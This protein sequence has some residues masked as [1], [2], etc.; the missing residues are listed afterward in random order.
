MAHLLRP[1]PRA[2][3]LSSAFVL[4]ISCWWPPSAE[5]AIACEDPET[6]VFSG[7]ID[8]NFAGGQE[9]A[10]AGARLTTYLQSVGAP[11][12]NFDSGLTNRWIAHTFTGL[13]T[14]IVGATLRFRVCGIAGDQGNDSLL[15]ESH[16]GGNFAW[17]QFLG[18]LA[19]GTPNSWAAGQCLVR[20]LDLAALP[21]GL[22]LSG[23]NVLASL[24]DG[25]LDF[26]VQDD[27]RVDFAELTVQHCPPADCA[28]PPR[29]LKAW[30]PFDEAAGNVTNELVQNA[31][32]AWSGNL[33]ATPGKVA[34]ALA[35]GGSSA[36]VT[37]P[38]GPAVDVGT[39]DFSIDFW[40]RSNQT[41]GI[42]ALLEKRSLNPAKGWTVFLSSGRLAFQMA[43]GGSSFCD[44]S[45]A[46]GCTN[47]DS[48]VPVADGT[49]KFIGITVDRDQP[50]GLRFYVGN[51]LVSTQNPTL[52]QGSLSNAAP[53]YFGRHAD[54]SAGSSYTGD[55]DEVELFDRVLQ[56]L[57]LL[58]ILDAGGK[59][60][61]RV[62][63]EAALSLCPNR[64]VLRSKPRICN[65]SSED[66]SY[67]VH[68]GPAPLSASCTTAGP[69]AFQLIG[70]QPVLVPARS[71]VD[72]Q[73]DVTR[74]AGMTGGYSC[75]NVAAE[76]LATGQVA[77]STS[78]FS[79][80]PRWCPFVDPDL[81]S[82]SGVPH[83]GFTE[84]IF[85]VENPGDTPVEAE[86]Q[87][88]SLA[89][90]LGPP[91]VRLEGGTPGNSLTGPVEIAPRGR[92]ELLFD[93]QID[94]LLPFTRQDLTLRDLT[95]GTLIA[96]KA[97]TSFAQTGCREDQRT[98]CLTEDR[99]E[100]KVVWR[101]YAGQ[102][103]SGFGQHLTGDTGY[104]WFFNPNNIE[105]VIKV[106]DGRSINERFWIFFGALSDVEF[107]VTVR[108]TVSGESRSYSNP[109]GTQASV[110]D[111]RG[112]PGFTPAA[113]LEILPERTVAAAPPVQPEGGCVAGATVL[114][115]QNGRFQL[116]VEWTTAVGG[117]GPG[118]AVPLT[119]ET[120]YFWFFSPN[121]V[122]LV[123]KVLDG[124]AINGNWWVFYGALSDVEYDVKV[125]DTL[126]GAVKTYHNPLA[127]FGSVGDTAAFP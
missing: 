23:T 78:R 112:L 101:D 36:T 7:G 77:A 34:G 105:L 126:T 45:T 66:A 47:Y 103:G 83:D 18:T 17:Y 27:S 125:T 54:G 110:G 56:P 57:E 35:F 127:T 30:W 88:E 22:G 70:S 90:D 14:G 113:A 119:S 100:V 108:D 24:A 80:R 26:V 121:N 52:R 75:F 93:V 4:A 64:N 1:S 69:T 21:P 71:C 114:C 9:P 48:G 51:Q 107:T 20:T 111:I 67:G 41:T 16:G 104:F 79:L 87:I 124:D 68:F 123:I 13:P 25:D 10:T 97:L 120:G 99:F 60:K 15:L 28:G 40:M 32:G 37:V 84:V 49:W 73:L 59:C 89:G 117:T 82:V 115:L 118:Q 95:D 55:L 65:D 2:R 19:G 46:L 63:G 61:D 53:L 29:G 58:T 109:L 98:L 74:P 44:S 11:I 43:E 39:E 81:P 94:E 38:N 33:A 91:V 72:L 86:V 96:S 106:L 5:A 116:E 102:T 31:D 12:Q 42:H 3:L 92:A 50:G 6:S 62:I 8:D 122:E 76:N 85:E